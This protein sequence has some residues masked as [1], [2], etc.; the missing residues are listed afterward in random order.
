MKYEKINGKVVEVSEEIKVEGKLLAL[1]DRLTQLEE[2]R[3]RTVEEID[4][5]TSFFNEADEDSNGLLSEQEVEEYVKINGLEHV[6][7]ALGWDVVES[8]LATRWNT[9]REKLKKMSSITLDQ[10]LNSF[11]DLKKKINDEPQA[12]QSLYGTTKELTRRKGRDRTKEF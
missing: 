11:G 8:E 3:V 9:F 10:F 1:Q 4:N 5:L 12:S 2:E 7:A 6:I